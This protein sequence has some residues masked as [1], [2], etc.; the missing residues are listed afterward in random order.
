MPIILNV[1]YVAY[2]HLFKEN[3]ISLI[4][5]FSGPEKMPRVSLTIPKTIDEL[6]RVTKRVNA[7]MSFAD[8]LAKEVGIKNRSVDWIIENGRCI[9][10]IVP[11]RS[12]LPGAGR[13][14]IAQRL[15]VRGE[16]IVPVPLLQIMDRGSLTIFSR[17]HLEKTGEDESVGTQMLLNYC[18]GHEESSLLLCP[19]T[20]AVL[21]NHCSARKGQCGNKGPNAMYRWDTTWD[22]TTKQ[23][24]NMTLDEL[25]EVCRAVRVFACFEMAS[26]NCIH[27]LFCP[28]PQQYGKGLS[29]E[30]IAL[31]DIQPGEEVRTMEI[32][33]T[34]RFCHAAL[35]HH[36]T[37]P[38][39]LLTMEVHGKMRGTS[40]WQTGS[41]WKLR[42][43][44]PSR[45]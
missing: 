21:I 12:T 38:R 29:F 44:I 4:H 19:L 39:F 37:A 16:V 22:R 27:S 11:G 17:E 30:I 36:I 25:H 20:N 15:V 13:G 23:W 10:N 41:K 33:L 6:D 26:Y 5:A 8:A 2:F 35:M 31:R 45:S 28:T 1:A 42:G 34:C 43:R 9:D 32:Q 18:F 7:S 40:T 3:T 14:A 24:L